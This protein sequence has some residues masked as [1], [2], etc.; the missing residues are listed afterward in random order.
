MATKWKVEVD[1]NR[2]GSYSEVTE[3]VAELQWF[4][5]FREPYMG[6]AS[7]AYLAFDSEQCG[8]ALLAGEQQR[9]AA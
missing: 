6:T 3:F 5:G 2:D 1:W 4:L 7:E 9:T 8:Q